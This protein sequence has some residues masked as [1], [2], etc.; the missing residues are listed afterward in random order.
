MKA[1]KTRLNPNNEQ[2]AFLRR[3][4]GAQ[5]FT[6][7]WGLAEWKRQYESGDK[8][9][10]FNLRK[11]F[12]AQKDE[13]CAWIRELP[14]SVVEAAFVNLGLAFEN[15][16][17][18]VKSG[19][20]KAGYPKFKSRHGHVSFQVRGLKVER[21]RVRITGVGWVRLD[22]RN[23]IPFGDGVEYG[24]YATVSEYA[25][26]WYV[27][28]L[29]KNDRQYKTDAGPIIGVDFGLKSLVVCS[30]GTVYENPQALREALAKLTRIQREMSRRKK[31]GA[32]WTKTKAKLQAAHARVANIRKHVLHQISHDL[33]VNRRPA[34]IVIEDLNVK[35]MT[36]NHCLA[37]SVNDASFAELRWQIEYKAKRYDVQ[38]IV[39]DRW[40]PSSKMCSACGA[41]KDDLTLADRVYVCDCGAVMDRDLNAAIN[42]AAYGSKNLQTAGD[43]LGS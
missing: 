43:C 11:Q 22:E 19:A 7:N 6:Y 33:V 21:D 41:I 32:N 24:T 17:R 40:F 38:V 31:G 36:A 8:P 35:G 28:V 27:S 37:L 23:Y 4:A 3:C 5:R 25:G 13:V 10:H 34:V 29:V 18:R 42:L 2:A 16:F 20:D 39:A 12:N 14:Y 1:Y 30:D 26:E 15:F 9:G